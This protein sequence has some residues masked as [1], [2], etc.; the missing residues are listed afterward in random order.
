MVEI[1]L[2]CNT[3]RCRGEVDEHF[4]CSDCF[5]RMMEEEFERGRDEGRGE[6]Q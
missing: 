5:K 6:Q 1:K 2:D 4:Y 3:L